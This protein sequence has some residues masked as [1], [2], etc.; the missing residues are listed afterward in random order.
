MR[1]LLTQLQVIH[2]LLLREMKTRFGRHQLGYG[3]ALLEPLLWIATF[4]VFYQ[5]LGRA[6]PPG[7]SAFEF[8]VTG[9]VPFVLFR[10]ASTSTLAAISANKGLLF[11][12]QIRPL[13]LVL[14]RALLE[15]AT[16][17]LVFA[18]LMGG[19]ALVSGSLRI[20]SLL[21]TILGL[22]LAAGLGGS[23]GLVLCGLSVFSP[24]VERIHGPLIRPLFWLSAIF[25]PIESAPSPLQGVLLLNPV[26]HA[27]ELVRDGW[28]SGYSAR[29][30]SPWYPA[31]WV[32][33]LLFFGLSLER[34]ARRRLELT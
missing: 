9:I 6:S 33:V 10:H 14:A 3:W 26:A 16:H 24:T 32:L 31:G 5:V 15:T 11:Y 22:S 18:L 2:A 27:I 29:H 30:V 28:F 1:G 34:V 19:A 23:F 12:P 21:E 25:H 8:L 4:M 7:M 17:I 13:D 20:D